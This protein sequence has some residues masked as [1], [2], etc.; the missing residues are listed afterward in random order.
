MSG[1]RIVGEAFLKSLSILDE[2]L[3]IETCSSSMIRLAFTAK[4]VDLIL[5]V[6]I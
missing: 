2:F 5:H 1:S 3:M 4:P 6:G